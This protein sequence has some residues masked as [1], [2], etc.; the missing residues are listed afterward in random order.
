LDQFAIVHFA[1]NDEHQERF[2]TRFETHGELLFSH[3]NLMEV[4]LLRGGSASAKIS[5]GV[6][7]MAA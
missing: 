3:M 5:S 7:A 1:S 2:F 6:R 4:G